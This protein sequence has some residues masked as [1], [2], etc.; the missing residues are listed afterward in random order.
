MSAV[1]NETI[2]DFRKKLE[3]VKED[4]AKQEATLSV[5]FKTIEDTSQTQTRKAKDLLKELESGSWRLTDRPL[6]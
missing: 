1:L 6:R 3:K 4:S 5:F 2:T